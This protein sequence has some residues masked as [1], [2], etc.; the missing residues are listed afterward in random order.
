VGGVLVLGVIGGIARVLLAEPGG[1]DGGR[2]RRTT[3]LAAA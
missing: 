3:G 2:R 1:R